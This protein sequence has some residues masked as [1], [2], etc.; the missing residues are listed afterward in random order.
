LTVASS[1]HR[2]A[3]PAAATTKGRGE[4]IDWRFYILRAILFSVVVG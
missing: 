2:A 4:D 3:I 1:A